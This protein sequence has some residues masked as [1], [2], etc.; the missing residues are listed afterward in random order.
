[1][2]VQRRLGAGRL[3][4]LDDGH[5]TAGVGGGRLDHGQA[6]EPPA[7]L[8]LV[9]ADGHRLSAPVLGIVSWSHDLLL[10]VALLHRMEDDRVPP[11]AVVA[12]VHH[13]DALLRD[14]ERDVARQQD[15]PRIGDIGADRRPTSPAP[16][17]AIASPPRTGW[18]PPITSVAPDSNS[19]ASACVVAQRAGR[20]RRASR[21]PP[22]SARHVVTLGV[23]AIAA[24]SRHVS[25]PSL[26]GRGYGR[27]CP[28][29]K[30]GMAR[31]RLGARM[32]A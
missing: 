23:P 11:G 24:S 15:A 31:R 3:R 12:A 30:C 20:P 32:R 28:F 17:R 6:P 29:Q 5:L 14:D 26:D 18:S 21:A 27:R 1:M 16:A 2:D 22:A 13:I 8:S 25:V 19:A 4:D 9:L 10:S 7:R